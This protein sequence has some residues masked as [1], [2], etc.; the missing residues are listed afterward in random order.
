[1]DKD[2]EGQGKWEDSG[3]GLLIAV[4]RQPRVEKK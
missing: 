1:M 2:S 4:E 3:G